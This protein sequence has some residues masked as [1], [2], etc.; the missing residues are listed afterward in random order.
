MNRATVE[1]RD[2]RA[3]VRD[4]HCTVAAPEAPRWAVLA[5][6]T[7]FAC[8]IP[9]SLWRAAVG[10]G[11]PLGWTEAQLRLEHIP[12]DGTRY[13]LALSVLSLAAAALTVGLVHRW[14]QVVPDWVPVLGRRQV[15][16]LAVVIPATLGALV[17]TALAAA[18]AL[19]W[20]RFSGFADNPD[21]GW[22]VL[23]TLCYAPAMLWGPMLLAVT[24]DHA[25]RRHRAGTSTDSDEQELT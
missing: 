24:I 19:N 7:A 14:G 10:L 17:V 22:A 1:R 6:Y 12:G 2:Q 9:S 5:A 8:V 15:P 11:V 3:R 23:M 25:R 18:S 13:V 4:Q 21:S 16:V 20:D